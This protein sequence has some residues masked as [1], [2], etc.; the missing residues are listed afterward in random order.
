MTEEI[1]LNMGSNKILKSARK[2]I[3]KSVANELIFRKTE[4]MYYSHI[5]TVPLMQVCIHPWINLNDRHQF[6]AEAR[7]H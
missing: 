5:N 7:A 3:L 2:P 6:N 4:Y 1:V